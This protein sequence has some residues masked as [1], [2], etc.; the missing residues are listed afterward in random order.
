MTNTDPFQRTLV[1]LET[2]RQR[3]DAIRART[4][5]ANGYP[6][7]PYD[8]LQNAWIIGLILTGEHRSIF[9]NLGEKAIADIGGLDGDM[10]FFMEHLGAAHVDMFDN[11]ATGMNAMDGARRLKS[12][13]NSRVNL[14]EVDVDGR[15]TLTRDY[16]L[17][18]FLGILYHLK[19]PFYAL[20]EIARHAR[21]IVL[22]TKVTAYSA[23]P[24]KPD[25]LAIGALPLA[26]L[27]GPNEANND[28]TNFWVFTDAG[29]LRLLDRSGWDILD[30]A[31]LGGDLA[32][33][34]PATNEG[35]RR[36]FCYLRSRRFQ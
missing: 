35:D 20:E 11:P 6:W 29:L 31:I 10:A 4:K 28:S 3:L 9:E 27:L 15:F 25:R 24:Q 14:H 2:F 17:V 1:E 13:L 32:A 7:S 36:A 33:S 8:C 5:P 21:H 22:S 18:L 34:D 26:Y 12:E 23:P 30:Y 19:N 16:D